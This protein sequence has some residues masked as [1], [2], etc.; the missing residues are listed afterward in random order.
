MRRR[1]G[2]CCQGISNASLPH[3][4]LSALRAGAVPA[5]VSLLHIVDALPVQVVA[6]AVQ[7]VGVA[8]G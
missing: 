6:P 3:S 1:H 7:V 5:G 8:R 2:V 4:L